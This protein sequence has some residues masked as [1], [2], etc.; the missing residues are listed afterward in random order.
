MEAFVRFCGRLGTWLDVRRRGLRWVW[1]LLPVGAAALLLF[2]AGNWPPGQSPAEIQSCAFSQ[3]TGRPCPLCGLTR[4]AG[5]FLHGRV[6]QSW[7]YHPAA[8]PLCVLLALFGGLGVWAAWRLPESLPP[9]IAWLAWLLPGIATALLA[10]T[11]LWR[12]TVP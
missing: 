1:C 3:V 7:H 6:R 2:A 10:A 9:M 11:W 4:G 5:A 12:L 8:A